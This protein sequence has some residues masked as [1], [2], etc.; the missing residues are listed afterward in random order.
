MPKLILTVQYA[1][2]MPGLPKRMEFRQWAKSAINVDTRI[3]LRLVDEAEGH[4]LNHDYRG[5]DYATNVLTFALAEEPH[6]M[7]DIVLCVPVVLREAGEQ[8]KTPD[9]HFAHLT[10]HGILHLR[11]YD[12]ENE[13]QAELMETLE[14]KII[15]K[16]GYPAP[17]SIKKENATHYG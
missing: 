2:D 8:N 9:A 16:L 13:A 6:L 11:G 12:H 1:S 5:K 4:S 10:V 7:G 15:T 17:Y 14:T 3:T